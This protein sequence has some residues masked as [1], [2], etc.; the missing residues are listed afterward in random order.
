[1]ASDCGT[2]E[3]RSRNRAEQSDLAVRC[4]ATQALNQ[5]YA[6]LSTPV[7]RWGS[8]ALVNN[9]T[10]DH[11]LLLGDA[12]PAGTAVAVVDE[13]TLPLDFAD[14]VTTSFPDIL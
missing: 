2:D 1:M 13:V 3:R 6:S 4:V 10:L 12:A 11:P 14:A 8:A 7:P 5:R 9:L